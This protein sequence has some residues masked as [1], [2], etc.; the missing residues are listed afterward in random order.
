[1]Q[2]LKGLELEETLQLLGGS[3]STSTLKQYALSLRVVCRYCDWFGFQVVPMAP[4]VLLKFLLWLRRSGRVHGGSVRK[5]TAAISKL[6]SWVGLQ[7]PVEDP[8][9]RAVLV[10]YQ[11]VTAGEAVKLNRAPLLVEHAQAIVAAGERARAQCKWAVFEACAAVVWQFVFFARAST[12]S[13]QLLEGVEC[14]EAEIVVRLTYEKGDSLPGRCVTFKAPRILAAQRREPNPFLLLVRWIEWRR[15]GTGRYLL[16]GAEKAQHDRVS[17]LW[18]LACDAAGVAPK[19]GARYLPH[20]ARHGGA[21]AASAAGVSDT[22]LQ[23]RGGW[24]S[25]ST[26]RCYVHEVTRHPADVLYFGAL[27]PTVAVFRDE[28]E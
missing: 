19:L 4:V 18:S 10:G 2:Q 8:M 27:A 22:V 7:S 21:S 23:V 28:D 12:L 20:S 25:A 3:L 1:V 6:H 13:E 16:S 15:T 9:V 26:L 24:R 14:T 11:R 17:R 5:F